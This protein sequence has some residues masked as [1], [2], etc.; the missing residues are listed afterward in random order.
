MAIDHRDPSPVVLW[1]EDPRRGRIVVSVCGTCRSRGVRLGMSVAQASELVGRQANPGDGSA[2]VILAM[3]DVGADAEAIT[4]LAAEVAAVISP[5]VAVEELDDV[6]WAGH[7]RHQSESLLVDITGSSHLFKPDI[8]DPGDAPEPFVP[9]DAPEPFVPSDA[10]EVLESAVMDAAATLLNQFGLNAR[11]AVADTP[12]AAW[13]MAH[14]GDSASRHHY[15]DSASRWRLPPGHGVAALVDLPIQSMRLPE[16]TVATLERLGVTR[17]GE[18]LRLP[19]S[20]LASRLGTDLIRRIDQL[21]GDRHESITI[22]DL[23]SDY[24]AAWTLKYPTDDLAILHDRLE[25]T[26]DQLCDQLM[27]DRRGANRLSCRLD[28]SGGAAL[29]LDVGLFAPSAVRDHLFDLVSHRL[30]TSV[31]SADGG[32]ITRITLSVVSHSPLEMRQTALFD[33]GIHTNGGKP[34]GKRGRSDGVVTGLADGPVDQ[35]QNDRELARLVDGLSIRLGRSGVLRI[36]GS[37]DPLPESSFDTTPLAGRDPVTENR[38]RSGG[39]PGANERPRRDREARFGPTRHDAM[40]RPLML[41]SRPKRLVVDTRVIHRSLDA[42]PWRIRLEGI[43]HRVTR[44]WGP[45]RIETGWWRH[46]SIRRD[47]Y[48]VETDRGRWLWIFRQLDGDDDPLE[49]VP[50][51]S[52]RSQWYL[53]GRFG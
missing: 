6:A 7:L 4:R 33:A 17:V 1:R 47:Y 45:E 50:A 46:G 44:I 39:S 29:H 41:L 22:A 3:H 21:T 37:P 15:G 2:D 35:L 19:R 20:G 48:R 30:E 26:L 51:T 14:Y 42:V 40:R 27:R 13:A 9:S 10:P 52:T 18:L 25:R 34:R 36:L 53:H 24:V 43:D 38:G 49:P 23:P 28:R 5:M 32:Q 16:S 12:A 11:L 31:A 8:P